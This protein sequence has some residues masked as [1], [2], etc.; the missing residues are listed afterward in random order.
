MASTTNQVIKR[1]GGN[2]KRKSLPSAAAKHHYEGCGVFVDAA[3]RATDVKVDATTVFAG[4]A[5]AEVD[6]SAGAAGDL[7]VEVWGDGD[8]ELPVT[9][10]TL[11]L[12]GTTVYASD[13][14]TY[15][16]TAGTNSI[17]GTLTKFVSTGIG[18]VTV[19]GLGEK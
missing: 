1:Q 15:T 11:A 6:N 9:G 13:N 8:F 10:A 14:N 7:N 2:W 18:I 5:I 17:V 4:I 16:M 12:Q 3:G 19:R